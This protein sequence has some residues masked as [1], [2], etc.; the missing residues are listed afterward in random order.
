MF[1]KI[2]SN[3]SVNPWLNYL[4]SFSSAW[5]LSAWYLCS[6]FF[7]RDKYSCA[8]FFNTSSFLK[9]KMTSNLTQ[10]VK[11][12]DRHLFVGVTHS[13]LKGCSPALT[14]PQRPPEGEYYTMQK[15]LQFFCLHSIAGCNPSPE[16]YGLSCT[17]DLMQDIRIS[18][19]H[20]SCLLCSSTGTQTLL[21]SAL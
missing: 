15:A 17:L 14:P 11:M 16:D 6:S 4:S 21:S 7:T 5:I 8:H 1:F 19:K 2:P 3:H 10:E 18:W 9:E 20:K 12:Q 13:C